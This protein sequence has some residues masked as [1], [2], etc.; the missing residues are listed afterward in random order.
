MR[1]RDDADARHTRQK[2]ALPLLRLCRSPKRGWDECP[3]QSIP[4]GEIERFVVEQI[5][6][7]GR[8]PELIAETVRQA[9][10][11]AIKRADELAAEELRLDR[12]LGTPSLLFQCRASN[13]CTDRR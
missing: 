7:I 5:K 3:S 6:N 10:E 8:A 4:A 12:E 11:R 1:L 13:F 9:R 2:Q